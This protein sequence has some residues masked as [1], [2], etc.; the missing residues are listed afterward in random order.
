VLNQ[1]SNFNDFIPIASGVDAFG[2]AFKAMKI[3]K[4]SIPLLI[5][6]LLFTTL[7]A[8][9]RPRERNSTRAL[10]E[11]AVARAL[12]WLHTQQQPNG[13]IGGLGGS[14]DMARVVALAGDDPDGPSWTP[15]QTSL[16][17]RCKLD[18]PDYLA[19]NDTGRLA[20]VLRAAQ[21]ANQNPHNFGGYDLLA[22]LQAQY[23]P[24]TGL[25]AANNLFRNSLALIALNEAQ[26]PVPAQAIAAVLAE[27]HDDGCWGWPVGGTVSDTDTSGL[28]LNAL[29]GAGYGD[30]PQVN[31]CIARLMAMQN[32]DGGW[33]L[34]GIYGDTESNVDSTAL[35]MQG[36]I[37]A[38]WDP[39]GPR[40]TQTQNA[41]QALLS[42]QAQDGAFWWRQGQAG[43]L[44]LGTQQ[45]IQ[46]LMMVYPNEIE[47]P[48]QL[49]QPVVQ[50]R[51][52][53]IVD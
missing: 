46:P 21:A 3:I 31:Q 8:R 37:A 40:L 27:Q 38:G 12:A 34:S 26:Q 30:A 16:L 13:A 53:V 20:K 22:R 19:R 25:Y 23:D 39:E 42:F 45:A 14:C 35:V 48:W 51:V 24:Q 10:R 32:D 1:V 6:I 7:P 47:K 52:M 36:L 49:Y 2:N 29:A 17:Q 41:T 4:K 33:E 18:L 9:A 11:A 15:E 5:F 44:L 28:M 50:T 43:S